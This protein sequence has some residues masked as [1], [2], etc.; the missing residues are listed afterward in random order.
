[1]RESVMVGDANAKW[2]DRVNGWLANTPELYWR[3]YYFCQCITYPRPMADTAAIDLRE[4]SK[5]GVKYVY[6]DSPSKNGDGDRIITMYSHHRPAR[7]F[8]DMCAMEAW[9]IEKL[10]WNPA[11][12]PETLRADFLRRTFGPSAAHLAAFFKTLRDSWYSENYWSSFND[13]S[14]RSAARYVVS[15]K[16]EGKCLA[17]L[18]AALG[19]AD[20]PERK[21]WIAKMIEVF[22]MW[23]RE[24][25]NFMDC[26]IAVPEIAAPASD[27]DGMEIKH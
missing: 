16:L 9:T 14:A 23:V 10:F 27:A 13:S 24:A 3:E 5:R 11:L 6:A 19:A 4:I 20:L 21:A 8:F 1:M 2:R 12:D 7:E 15:K 25:P 18:E 17:D 26:E 22:G